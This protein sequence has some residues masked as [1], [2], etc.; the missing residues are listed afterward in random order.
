MLMYTKYHL[1]YHTILCNFDSGVIMRLL[2][3]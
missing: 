2:L 3:L 1:A